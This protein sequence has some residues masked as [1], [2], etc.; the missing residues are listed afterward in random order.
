MQNAKCKCK[1][2]TP[3]DRIVGVKGVSPFTL[4][5]GAGQGLHSAF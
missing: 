5:V 3:T 4:L 1:M 2:Q